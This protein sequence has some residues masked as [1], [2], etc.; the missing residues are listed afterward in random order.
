MDDVIIQLLIGNTSVEEPLSVPKL[1]ARPLM[2]FTLARAVTTWC[3]WERVPYCNPYFTPM[4]HNELLDHL[5]DSF[6]QGMGSYSGSQFPPGSSMLDVLLHI[7]IRL[8]TLQFHKVMHLHCTIHS[9]NH[10]VS[11]WL[12]KTSHKSDLN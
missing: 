10:S 5:W 4:P 1:G 7:S 8:Y 12:Q 11:S 6:D 3:Q 2:S 9:V